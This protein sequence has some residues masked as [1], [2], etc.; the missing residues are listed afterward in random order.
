MTT[1]IVGLGSN[2][3]D[4][5]FH[6]RQAWKL[7]DALENTRVL[8]ISHIYKSDAML[9][10]HAPLDWN[11]PYLNLAIRC[12]TQ[13]KPLAFLNEV[14]AIE[15]ALG[16]KTEPHRWGPRIIDIDIL[17][18]ETLI[19][20]DHQLTLPHPYLH[21]RPF[22]LWPLADLD[23]FWVH[24]HH[25]KTAA[26]MVEKWGSRFSG[27]APFHTQ[28]INQRLDKPQLV[29]I[30]NVTPD[31]FSDGGRYLEADQALHQAKQ[32]IQSGAEILD[33]GAESTAPNA[34]PIQIHIEWLRLEPVLSL[35]LAEKSQFLIPP[36]ISIDTR[37]ASIAQ[38]ALNLGVDWINDVSGLSGP[39]MRDIIANSMAHCVV[40]HHLTIPPNR[41]HVLP[42]EINPVKA[43]Y[44]WAAFHF[45]ALE[46]QGIPRERIIFDAGI[47]FGKTPEQSLY[48]LKHIAE[49]KKLG[50]RQLVG[51]SRKSFFSQ[52]SPALSKERD[53]ETLAMTLFLANQ[54]VDYLR[55][56]NV[57]MSAR[58]LKAY[59][60]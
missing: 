24:P 58:G 6:L 48:L 30:I 18:W 21:E 5:L 25:E 38:K 27:E 16:R 42:R 52:L 34:T 29:G 54:S 31:S 37:H 60:F 43:V 10:D 17:T 4:R 2:V 35:L 22:A 40:M 28:Q 36:K 44:D 13:L 11:L 7:I 53:I 3:G 49:F 45:E 19:H 33:I 26:V 41:F 39:A 55:V 14:K 32:L 57:E 12:D 23:P 59:L 47:G 1:V 51:H 8:T 15:Q 50:T 56:H 9:K 20:D 46:A